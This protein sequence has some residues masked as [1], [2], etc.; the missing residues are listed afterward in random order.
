MGNTCIPVVDYFLK[1]LKKKIKKKKKGKEGK[2]K[3]I[4][5]S[6]NI[7]PEFLYGNTFI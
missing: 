3:I 6:G 7:V 1:L 4:G 5:R 2:K